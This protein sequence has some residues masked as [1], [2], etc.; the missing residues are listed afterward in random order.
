MQR[1]FRQAMCR[2]GP[3]AMSRG[4]CWQVGLPPCPYL[5]RLGPRAGRWLAIGRRWA[6][7]GAGGAGWRSYQSSCALGLV[8][9]RPSTWVKSTRKPRRSPGERDPRRPSAPDGSVLAPG[10]SRRSWATGGRARWRH[11]QRDA[12]YWPCSSRRSSSSMLTASSGSSPGPTSA[13][14]DD[15]GGGGGRLAL[16]ASARSSWEAHQHWTTWGGP[17]NGSNQ[18]RPLGTCSPSEGADTP[19]RRATWRSGKLARPSSAL[20]RLTFRSSAPTM[21]SSMAADRRWVASRRLTPAE[22]ASRATRAIAMAMLLRAAASA[23]R[24]SLAAVWA[25]VS[26][27]DAGSLAPATVRLVNASTITTNGGGGSASSAHDPTPAAALAA[28]RRAT[29]A[30]SRSRTLAAS[31]MSVAKAAVQARRKAKSAPPFTGSITISVAPA[32]A[33]P[34]SSAWA[35]EDLPEPVAP[36]SRR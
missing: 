12:T 1:P 11:G 34:H 22:R 16:R 13:A 30:N 15:P 32:A 8:W 29:S 31:V 20:A 18:P 21:R 19:S 6:H 36:A 7:L 5:Q 25:G 10:P 23:S 3:V 33:A 14:K 26:L 24:A 9:Y 17:D 35:A 27:G 2:Y 28:L 4:D